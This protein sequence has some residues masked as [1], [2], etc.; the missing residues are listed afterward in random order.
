MRERLKDLRKQP[1]NRQRNSERQSVDDEKRFAPVPVGSLDPRERELLE[2]LCVHPELA[3]D[4]LQELGSEISHRS[5][6]RDV[7][8]VYRQLEEA[9]QNLEFPVVLG[10]L[11][12]TPQESADRTR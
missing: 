10:E 5:R 9:G 1:R 12:R 11:P 2:L 4:R 8:S 7:F 3:A 6:R